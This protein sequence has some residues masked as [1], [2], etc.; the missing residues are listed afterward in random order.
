MTTLRNMAD[1]TG[2]ILIEEPNH[3]SGIQTFINGGAGLKPGMACTGVGQPEGH[4]SLITG[5]DATAVGI[6]L[7]DTTNPLDTAIPNPG[8]VRV[9]MRASGALVW[10][11]YHGGA[12]IQP[13]T[14]HRAMADQ[15]GSVSNSAGST[16]MIGTQ[17][18]Y[19]A[20]DVGYYHPIKLRLN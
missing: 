9:A 17:M 11:F 18:E 14:E 15:Q 19:S 7:D 12:V 4:V 20:A 10:A 3:A 2:S 6:V 1:Y 8:V 13:G 16:L 5:A